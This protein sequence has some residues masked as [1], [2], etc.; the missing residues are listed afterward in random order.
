[1]KLEFVLE[2]KQLSLSEVFVIKRTNQN[3]Q[4][5][6]RDDLGIHTKTKGINENW[7]SKQESQILHVQL[8]REVTETEN[9][10]KNQTRMKWKQNKTT[11]HKDKYIC[12]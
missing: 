4:I 9:K 12:L 6:N 8:P 7:S 2:L 1:M 3:H 5:K 11:I 10:D